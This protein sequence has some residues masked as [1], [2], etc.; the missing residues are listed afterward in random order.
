MKYLNIFSIINAA[1]EKNSLQKLKK[2]VLT[3]ENGKYVVII[4]KP[5]I[6]L[7]K[8]EKGYNT[9]KVLKKTFL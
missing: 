7:E 3:R 9:K 8:T 6:A 5:V 1:I 2:I 4:E